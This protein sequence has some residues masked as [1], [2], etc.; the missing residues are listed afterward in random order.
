MISTLD[1]ELTDDYLSVVY[2]GFDQKK[3]RSIALYHFKPE[4]ISMLATIGALRGSTKA[5][6]DPKLKVI[7]LQYRANITSGFVSKSIDQLFNEG[8]LHKEKSQDSA[9]I[10]ESMTIQ[11][12]THSFPDLAALSLYKMSEKGLLTSRV[13]GA[14]LPIHL[15][16]PAAASLPLTEAGEKQVKDFC[17]AF[18]PLLKTKKDGKDVNGVFSESIFAQQRKN[19]ITSVVTARLAVISPGL[20][21]DQGSPPAVKATPSVEEYLADF[22]QNYDIDP[23]NWTVGKPAPA[24]EKLKVDQ[25]LPSLPFIKDDKKKQEVANAMVKHF[26]VDEKTPQS[27]F[28]NFVKA[29]KKSKNN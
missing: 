2:Q 26:L 20:F 16:F 25:I 29:M 15:Q 22:Y 10:S 24:M 18:S 27:A 13:P 17:I 28:Q 9:I 6:V 23:K 7:T 8:V 4:S 1:A 21:K 3:M 11:R 19:E 5:R 14:V 12:I